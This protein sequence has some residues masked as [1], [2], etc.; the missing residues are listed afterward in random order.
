MEWCGNWYH[1]ERADNECEELN[2][3]VNSTTVLKEM[4]TKEKHMDTKKG[5]I[6]SLHWRIQQ[7]RKF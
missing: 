1:Q 4:G 2:N 7:I 5:K 3:R 6:I